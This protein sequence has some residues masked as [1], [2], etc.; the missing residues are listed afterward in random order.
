MKNI[1]VCENRKLNT[2]ND[3]LG[4]DGENNAMTLRFHF[5]EKISGIE[6]CR[7]RKR[8][9][10]ANEN[11]ICKRYMLADNTCPL[12]F[13]LTQGEWIEMQL[14]LNYK[15]I[16]WLSFPKM[17]RFKPALDCLPGFKPVSDIEFE[18]AFIP[19]EV[20]DLT[21]VGIY[22]PD[23][24]PKGTQY[25]AM[26]ASG[27]YNTNLGVWSVFALPFCENLSKKGLPCFIHTPIGTEFPAIEPFEILISLPV[28][29]SESEPETEDWTQRDK[30]IFIDPPIDEFEID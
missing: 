12:T 5:P 16:R 11:G 24:I 10:F 17:F 2:D 28:Y 7:F 30:L 25:S 8:I 23:Y 1:T 26:P 3:N 27:E 6:T 29:S 15:D 14:E 9:V 21:A 19:P 20:E 18:C 4:V 13:D 22:V